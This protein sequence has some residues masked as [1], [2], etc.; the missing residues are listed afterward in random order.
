MILREVEVKKKTTFSTNI[1]PN[2]RLSSLCV[3]LW[4]SRFVVRY[5]AEEIAT[6]NTLGSFACLDVCLACA[7]CSWGFCGG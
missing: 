3:P 1:T 7:G 4:H 5:F 6:I 2:S